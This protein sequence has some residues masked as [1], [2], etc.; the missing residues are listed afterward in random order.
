MLGE[1]K[2]HLSIQPSGDCHFNNCMGFQWGLWVE[3]AIPKMYS[4]VTVN[5]VAF[6]SSC[7]NWK[8]EHN[9]K[10]RVVSLDGQNCKLRPGTQC[11][12]ER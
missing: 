6:N 12:R 9:Q 1:K 3:P 10:L 8:K 4:E 2:T 5:E 7:V 11:L